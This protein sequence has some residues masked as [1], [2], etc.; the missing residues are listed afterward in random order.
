MKKLVALAVS[1]AMLAMAVPATADDGQTVREQ[2]REFLLEENPNYNPNE[3]V[4]VHHN[5]ISEE[6]TAEDALEITLDRA[7][8]RLLEN[9][10]A[11]EA[12]GTAE[13]VGDIWLIGF[14]NVDCGTVTTYAEQSE[15]LGAHA[16]FWLYSGDVGHANGASADF[17]SANSWTMKDAAAG[18][19]VINY[20]GVSDFFCI[21]GGF[22]DLLFPFIDGYTTTQTTVPPS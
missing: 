19:G 17:W 5:G 15:F 12:H 6:M 13:L 20:G 3:I 7:D 21:E 11:D 18:S 2:N 22:F 16:Q 1:I 4:T 9:I 8:D 14:G 10:V